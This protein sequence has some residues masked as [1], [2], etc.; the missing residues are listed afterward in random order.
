MTEQE[1]ASASFYDYD[2]TLRGYLLFP[3]VV[4]LEPC[5]HPYI[6]YTPQAHIDDGR[7][8]SFL[9]RVGTFFIGEKEQVTEEPEDNFLAYEDN[10]D[11][12]LTSFRL[13]LA[14]KDIPSLKATLSLLSSLSYNLTSASFEI[15]ATKEKISLYVT[16]AKDEGKRFTSLMHS[17]FPEVGL[18]ECDPFDLP[19][20]K[21]EPLA[22]VDF[23]LDEECVKPL[24]VV[25]NFKDDPLT[26]LLANMA[27]LSEGETALLQVIVQGTLALWKRELLFAVSDGQGGSFF[28]DAPE[29]PQLAKEKTGTPLF[30]VVVRLAVQAKHEKANTQLAH[31]LI[32]CIT[33]CS[34]SG[35]NRLIPLSNE[36]Y[37]YEDHLRNLYQRKSNRLG[38]LLSSHELAAFVHLPPTSVHEKLGGSEE[39]TK[40]LPSIARG[41]RYTIG[42]NIHQGNKEPAT[43][44]DESRLRHTHILGA[45]G[46]G[47]STFIVS[48]ILEDIAK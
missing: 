29:M 30:S 4:A 16:I 47:K 20:E 13:Q 46:T 17:F 44:D 39:K 37:P 42:T 10:N 38:M 18:E 28:A 40:A 43:L 45:T 15:V 35:M 11:L 27:Y 36:G 9:E 48:L 25:N 22:V 31:H 23:G 26:P 2:R 21:Q 24:E 3:H 8:P 12:P 7:V 14:K 1:K 6:P 32:E 33:E 34:D 41:K 19:F 5:F